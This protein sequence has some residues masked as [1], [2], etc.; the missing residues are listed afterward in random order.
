M[1]S[2][3]LSS[4][5]ATF[6][7]LS[8]AGCASVQKA[9]D[10]ID[11]SSGS[12][13]SGE[14]AL[15][16]ISISE[17]GVVPS[18]DSIAERVETVSQQTCGVDITCVEGV[19]LRVVGVEAPGKRLAVSK[20]FP[21]KVQI[22]NKGDADMTTLVDV[23]ATAHGGGLHEDPQST[24]PVKGIGAGET[25]E[26][27]MPLRAFGDHEE[28]GLIEVEVDPDQISDD[29]DTYNNDGR[30][31]VQ[32]EAPEIEWLSAE[33]VS[34][35]KDEPLKFSFEF[36][37]RAHV[38]TAPATRLDVDPTCYEGEF[39]L[40]DIEVPA[41]PPQETFGGTFTIEA[42]TGITAPTNDGYAHSC[43]WV[44]DDD[45]SLASNERNDLVL[46]IDPDGEHTW[47]YENNDAIRVRYSVTR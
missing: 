22:L 36:R 32:W 16:A 38:A 29:V 1:R 8:F 11:L 4:V 18:D 23:R 44:D 43:Y 28:S 6:L 33:V 5:L 40:P 17:P 30:L 47:G 21:L 12:S 42:G 14:P 19:D 24:L 26:V 34:A 10:S 35:E 9:V 25:V 15:A 39:A 20:R 37:N 46:T 3:L 41:I 31:D 2:R 27:T 13:V 45:Y 7:V